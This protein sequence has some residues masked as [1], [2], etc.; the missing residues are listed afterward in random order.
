MSESTAFDVTEATKRCA[1]RCP[2]LLSTQQNLHP[3]LGVAAVHVETVL[4][5]ALFCDLDHAACIR[6]CAEPCSD[7]PEKYDVQHT[8]TY[9][10]AR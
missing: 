1:L 2:N 3:I 4:L 5:H 6:P 10:I 7:S 8:R 9:D